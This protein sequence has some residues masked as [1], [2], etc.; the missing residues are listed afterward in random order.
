MKKIISAMLATTFIVAGISAQNQ[1]W[2]I[3]GIILD[4]NAITAM[5]LFNWSQTTN[6]ISTARAT[7]MGGALTSL[8]GDAASMSVNPAGLG[9]YRQNDITITPAVGIAK[10][11]TGD[12]SAYQSNKSGNFSIGNFGIVLKAYEGTGTVMAVNLGFGYSRLADLNY[13]TSYARVG[14][15]SS[16]SGVF[17]R[18]LTNGGYVSS[19]LSSGQNSRFSWWDVAPED[20]GAVLGYKCGLVDDPNGYWQPDMYGNNPSVDQYVTMLSKGAI[21]EYDL[22]MGMNIANKLYFGFSLGLQNLRQRR[23]I[24]YSEE[25]F[26]ESAA[27]EPAGMMLEGFNYGQTSIASGTGVNF[28]VGLTYRPTSALRIGAAFHSPTWYSVDFRYGGSMVSR[29][30]DNA[31]G[32]YVNPDP[33]AYTETWL[34]AGRDSWNFRTPARLLLGAS[35]T[36]GKMAILSVDYERAWYGNIRTQDTPVGHGAF[37]GFF[38]DYFKGSNSLRAGVEIKPVSLMAVRAGYGYS[39]SMLKDNATIFSSPVNYETQYVAGGLGFVLSNYF[40]LDL[41]YR[42]TMQKYTTAKLFYAVDQVGSADDYSGDFKTD[43][44]RHHIILTLGFRF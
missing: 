6:G 43:I 12:T 41:A 35:Y 34:D 14:N 13:H 38:K 1:G 11:S 31:A 19:N 22:S 10:S 33:D 16:I 17:A 21:G 27:D 18:Q 4:P 23:E 15:A 8:G 2:D 29:V 36:F 24:Y 40:Y 42:Y 3:G 9:M 44:A 28:K 39:G 25:Y 20:W 30:L 5:D 32:S 26:Y 37:N 7:A